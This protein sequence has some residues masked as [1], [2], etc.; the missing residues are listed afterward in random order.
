VEGSFDGNAKLK[1]PHI[2]LSETLET[3]GCLKT[4]AQQRPLTELQ[5]G[6]PALQDRCM[7]MRLKHSQSATCHYPVWVRRVRIKC[8]GR[9]RGRRAVGEISSTALLSLAG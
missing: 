5:A 2:P 6:P 1:G 4:G 3:A 7:W 9:V 8:L